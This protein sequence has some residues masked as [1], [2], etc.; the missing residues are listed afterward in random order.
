MG[1]Y[2][3]TVYRDA[4]TGK[5]ISEEE[6]N[7]LPPSRVIREQMPNPGRGDTGRSK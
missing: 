5:I 6:A 7:R 2:T 1:Q 4:L 3:H